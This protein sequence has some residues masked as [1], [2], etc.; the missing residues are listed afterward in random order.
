MKERQWENEIRNTGT[1]DRYRRYLRANDSDNT[2]ISNFQSR[3]AS[4]Q[5][6]FRFPEIDGNF[7]FHFWASLNDTFALR[8]F[9]RFLNRVQQKSILDISFLR[10]MFNYFSAKL[11]LTY[12]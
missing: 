12:K 6:D 10:I 8:I 1:L 5:S 4:L 11:L 7:S 2:S 3:H 9:T